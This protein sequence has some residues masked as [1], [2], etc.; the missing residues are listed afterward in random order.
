MKKLN[1]ISLPFYLINIIPKCFYCI[2]IRA[3]TNSTSITIINCFI[4]L[5]LDVTTVVPSKL[6]SDLLN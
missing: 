6:Y 4:Q 1:L 2:K 5:V 3:N